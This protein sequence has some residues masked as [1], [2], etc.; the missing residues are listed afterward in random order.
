MRIKLLEIYDKLLGYFGPRHWWPA[1][2]PFEMMVGAV[3]TQAVAWRNVEK[4]IGNL[5]D[6]DLLDPIQ[7]DQ[8]DPTILEELLKPTRYYKMKTRKL[9]ALNRFLVENYQGVPEAMFHEKLPILRPKLL[10]IYGMGPETVDSILLYAGGIPIF[11]IDAYTQKIFHRL[12]ITPAKISYPKLQEFFM[13][14]LPGDPALYNE[15]HAQI[16]ALGNKIC[17]NH[18]KCGQ[19]PLSDECAYGL[20]NRV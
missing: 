10:A 2:T 8:T 5:K 16:V 20:E 3:L 19:C 4:A 6:R 15:F 7:L 17:H 14:H 1:E 12:G 13:N 11:V 9:Q 18:P